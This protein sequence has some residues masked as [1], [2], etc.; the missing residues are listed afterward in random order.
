MPIDIDRLN[1]DP[2]DPVGNLIK[3]DQQIR[4]T[5]SFQKGYQ[6]DNLGPF[7]DYCDLFAYFAENYGTPEDAAYFV[8]LA[9]Q[10][11]RDP[12]RLVNTFDAITAFV[13]R[14]KLDY[15][16]G[17]H[18]GAKLDAAWKV[19]IHHYITLIRE[20]ITSS[21]AT[22]NRQ[23]ELLAK[24]DGLASA[25]DQDRNIVDRSIAV[26]VSLCTG[27][28]EGAK[29]LQP[30]VR[31]IQSITGSVSRLSAEAPTRALPPPDEVA[32]PEPDAATSDLQN[33]G[34]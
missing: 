1:F 30:A 8:S 23:A 24:L 5:E 26:F 7:V 13:E 19:R 17:R 25:V 2:H 4:P 16:M 11:E 15:V 3:L 33:G 22:P 18:K 28:S 10:Q 21:N 27:I 9:Q 31:L 14:K 12:N 29:Q 20:I 34:Q 32:L 6:N